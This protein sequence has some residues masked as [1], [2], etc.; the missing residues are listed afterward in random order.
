M[1]IHREETSWRRGGTEEASSWRD[2]RR[3]DT[4]DRDRGERRD[5]DRRDDRE[6]RAPPRDQDE[7]V[8]SSYILTRDTC[9]RHH[10]CSFKT[11]LEAV[12]SLQI[13]LIYPHIK[14]FFSCP[15]AH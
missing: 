15:Q 3:E 9:R 10:S 14:T 4:T 7:G 5:R 1:C 8:Q 6:I 12:E 13:C 2:S 11:Y